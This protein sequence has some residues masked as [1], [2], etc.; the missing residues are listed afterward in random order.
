MKA[1]ESIQTLLAR[2]GGSCQY[3]GKKLTDDSAQVDTCLPVEMGG[4]SSF[5]NFVLSCNTCKDTLQVKPP[6]EKIEYAIMQ[7]LLKQK[8]ANSKGGRPFAENC[9]NPDKIDWSKSNAE[10]GRIHGVSREAIR[11]LRQRY[12]K[13][14]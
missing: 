3:C 13:I 10:N 1:K 14:E 9:I 7:R 8:N 4:N 5:F 2:Y 12:A 6:A 11:Q